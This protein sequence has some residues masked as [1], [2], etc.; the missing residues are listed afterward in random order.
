MS[1]HRR[2][3]FTTAK[4]KKQLQEKRQKKREKFEQLEKQ[5]KEEKENFLA[6]EKIV[7]KTEIMNITNLNEQKKPEKSLKTVFSKQSQKEYDESL[8]SSRKPLKYISKEDG[9][10][11]YIPDFSKFIEIPKRPSWKPKMTSQEIEKKE[12]IYFSQ[13]LENLEKN[14]TDLN[15]FEHNIE[16]FRQLWRTI[17]FSD[18]VL[19]VV[20]VRHPLFHFPPSLYDYL[21][22]E[23]KKPMILILNKCDL[24]SQIMVKSW[25]SFFEEKYPQLHCVTFAS[26]KNQKKV[27]HDE[28]VKSI[29]KKL[30]E[31]FEA[32][33]NETF[34]KYL[35]ELFEEKN[36]EKHTDE[37]ITIGLLGHPN[38]GKSCL[39]NSLVGRHVVSTSASPGH[40]KHYQTYF[41]SQHVRLCDC[42][43][44][45]FP[46]HAMPKELQVLCGLFPIAQVKEPYSCVKYI[47]E[48]VDVVKLLNLKHPGKKSVWTA[49][50]ICEAYAIKVG[51]FTNK[52]GKPD[53]YRG[54]NELLRMIFQGKI[55][56]AFLPPKLF[57]QSIDDINLEKVTSQ[58]EK[59]DLEVDVDK[60][61]E[62]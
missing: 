36:T 31:I 60:K 19:L 15:Y 5:E 49:W 1:S 32:Q 62:K 35:S 50:D 43:G 17:E 33:K 38:V 11:S 39:L 24:V 51:Y 13:Y 6:K 59:K 23:L 25:K 10:Y 27:V 8:R 56:F 22:N 58:N 20:D 2:V 37:Y 40:T 28:D 47:A 29:Y 55:M 4:K 18:V 53:V 46:A 44:L 26:Y 30:I 3:P 42:P 34:L 41:I 54:A 45:I 16:V 7:E 9:R 14:F 57:E 61:T 48:R 12:E 21:V 52:G